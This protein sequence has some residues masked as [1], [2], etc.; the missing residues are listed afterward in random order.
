MQ[1]NSP[2]TTSSRRSSVVKTKPRERLKC[3]GGGL[4]ISF[5]DV[6]SEQQV[7]NLAPRS[8]SA[9]LGMTS[10]SVHT[11]H[12]R[13]WRWVWTDQST[14]V[15]SRRSRR[16]QVCAMESPYVVPRSIVLEPSHFIYIEER[17]P[18]RLDVT[19]GRIQSPYKTTTELKKA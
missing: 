12:H 17:R 6:S 3:G 1:R 18:I 14:V 19:A 13:R 9:H 8:S 2:D 11:W 15:T 7:Y 10:Y 16:H 5:A 4:T